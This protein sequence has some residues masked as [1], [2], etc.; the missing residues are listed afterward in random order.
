M[1]EAVLE[2]GEVN[3]AGGEIVIDLLEFFLGGDDDPGGAGDL[4]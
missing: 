2:F 3:A 4:F 1:F